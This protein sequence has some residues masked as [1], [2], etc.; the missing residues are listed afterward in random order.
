MVDT[1]AVHF[2]EQLAAEVKELEAQCGCYVVLIAESDPNDP[3]LVR[4]PEV[5]D[6]GMDAQ[7]GD[8]SIALS[9][10][11]SLVSAMAIYWLR[12]PLPILPRRSSKCSSTMIAIP[13]FT[14]GG[15][16]GHWRAL[17]TSVPR[18]F[19][20]PF[21]NRAKGERSSQLMHT[22]RLKV[23]AALVCTVCS[24]V[25][26]RRGVGACSLFLYFTD[27]E[28]PELGQAVGKGRR[29]EFATFSWEL[30]RSP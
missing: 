6:H 26:P 24:P 2:L 16:A 15:T 18:L 12:P 4:S 29:E 1:T 3:R 11:S 30:V 10:R 25:V 23:A 8:D 17:R 20:E 22:G 28:D 27:H 5:G 13:L 14:V 21:G 19:A 7:W 9:R